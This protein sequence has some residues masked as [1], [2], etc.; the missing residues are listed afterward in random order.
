MG[1]LEA[2]AGEAESLLLMRRGSTR[3]ASSCLPDELRNNSPSGWM[4]RL[5][6]GFMVQ[7]SDPEE[8]KI[9]VAEM[10]M[11]K[12][13]EDTQGTNHRATRADQAV[14][15]FDEVRGTEH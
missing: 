11:Q 12:P 9:E 6:P 1:G 5:S 8:N 10:E 4:P 3:G 14:L 13:P 2:D 15:G 7:V